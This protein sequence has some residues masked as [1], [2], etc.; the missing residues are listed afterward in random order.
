VDPGCLATA[1]GHRR[2]A[3]ILLYLCGTGKSAPLLNQRHQRT[4][5]DALW[6]ERL[7]VIRVTQQKIQ[8]QFRIRRGIF[9]A[10]WC[11]R[12]SIIRQRRRVD[13]KNEL[14]RTCRLETKAVNIARLG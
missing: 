13:R 10:A 9:G 12:L 2:N 11:K 3:R 7:K 6:L 4:H 1:L 14:K 8:G 5:L